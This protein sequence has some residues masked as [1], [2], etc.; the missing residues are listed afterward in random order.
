VRVCA[1]SDL[2]GFRPEIP[3]CDLLLIGGDVCLDRFHGIPASHDP[4]LQAAWFAGK[5]LPWLEA[6]PCDHV[7]LTW[8]NH[9]FC[10][11]MPDLLTHLPKLRKVEIVVDREVVVDGVRV[12]LTPW[13]NQFMD[14]AF[15]ETPSAL[16]KRYRAIPEGI[17]ILV[18]HQ[19][20]KGCGDRFYDVAT[21]RVEHFGSWELCG[22]IARVQPKVVICGHIHGGHGDHTY[23]GIPVHNVSVVDE[24]YALV[25]PPTLFELEVTV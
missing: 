21:G 4:R 2:H 3:E 25:N 14:W 22:A 18:S 16:G 12:W 8:G 6:A 23:E 19:P 24:R 10:G 20:P 1:M 11:Q 15:M 7:L 17:D 5:V 13:S 9:D